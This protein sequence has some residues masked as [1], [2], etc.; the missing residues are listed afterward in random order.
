[1]REANET[2]RSLCLGPDCVGD[3]LNPL[4]KNLSLACG[5]R[6]LAKCAGIR[7]S[8]CHLVLSL[9]LAWTQRG[10]AL[11]RTLVRGSLSDARISCDD[12]QV[13]SGTEPWELGVL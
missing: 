11:Q 12:V 5:Q 6:I 9:C 8:R 10:R 2:I 13:N 1:M 3:R 7:H 4:W